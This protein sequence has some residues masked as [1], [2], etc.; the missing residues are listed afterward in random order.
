MTQQQWTK[1]AD[2]TI[3]VADGDEVVLFFDGS[4]SRDATAPVG[5]RVDDG[6]VFTLGVWE[7]DPHNPDE[8]VDA[9]DV[10]RVVQQTFDRFDV[11]GFFA[12]CGSGSRSP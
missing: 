10:D 9:P 2:P 3:T 5:C 11:V 4:T 1:L 12:M 6:H 8:T 7:P